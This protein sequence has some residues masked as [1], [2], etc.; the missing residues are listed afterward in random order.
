MR[1]FSPGDLADLHALYSDPE[2][3]KYIPGGNPRT[4]DETR[5]SLEKMMCNFERNDYGMFAVFERKEKRFISR[6]GLQPLEN[7]G[8]IELSYTFVPSAWG[9]GYATEAAMEVL[10]AAFCDWGL[11]KV[12]AIAQEENRASTRVMEKIG[13]QNCGQGRFYDKD[14]VLYALEREKKT[15]D[16]VFQSSFR[17]SSRLNMPVL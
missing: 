16:A 14:V 6:C 10:R 4:L 9:K 2:V 8:L 1:P 13:M 12:V 15:V 11:E 17:Q 5:D 7:S 3:M